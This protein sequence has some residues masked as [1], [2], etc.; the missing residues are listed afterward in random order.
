ML[1]QVKYMEFYS[2][3]LWVSSLPHSLI[4][5]LHSKLLVSFPDTSGDCNWSTRQLLLHTSTHTLLAG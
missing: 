4:V 5:Q 2:S 3:W 1:L